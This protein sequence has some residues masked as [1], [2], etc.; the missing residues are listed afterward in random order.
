M[1][2]ESSGT[3]AW[4]AM[5]VPILEALRDGTIFASTSW[6]PAST[7]VSPKQSSHCSK[8]KIQTHTGP[9]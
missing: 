5:A 4:L 8:I 1:R 7:P 3:L 6:I 2:D 9:N